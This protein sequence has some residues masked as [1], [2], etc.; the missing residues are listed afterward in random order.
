MSDTI[1]KVTRQP[2]RNRVGTLASMPEAAVSFPLVGAVIALAAGAVVRPFPQLSG[3]AYALWGIGLVVTGV[4]V[5]WRTLGGVVRG[6]LAADV[7]AAIA[8]V[9]AFA[10]GNPAVGLIV[11]IM[12]TGGEAL[13]RYARKRAADTTR[14]LENAAPRLA[15]RYVGHDLVDIPAEAIRVGD[16]LFVR[17]GELIPCDGIVVSGRSHVDVSA[18]TGEPLPVTASAGTQLSSGSLNG[19]GALTLR[20]LALAGESEYARIVELVRTAQQHKAPIQRTAD[21]YAVWF[22]PFTI[23]LAAIAYGISGDW[24][25][26]LAVLVVATPCPLILATPV[27]IIGGVNRAARR[28]IVFRNGTALEQLGQVGMVVLDKTGTITIGRP[29]VTK[30]VTWPGFGR[31]ELLQLAASVEESSSHVLAR[32]L[33]AAAHAEGLD[34]PVATAS[35]EF[36]GQGVSGEVGARTVTVGARSFLEETYPG[37]SNTLGALDGDR[38]GVRAYV[39]VDGSAAGFVDYADA[40]RP[41]LATMRRELEELGLRR[42]ML[43]SGDE[44]SKTRAVAAAAGI[45]EAHGD[46]RP[47]EKAT[48]VSRLVNSG[49]KVVMIGDGTNDAPA[50]STATVGIALAARARGIA[51][52]AADVVVLADDLT[53]VPEAIRLSRRTMRIARQGIVVG[54]GLSVIGMV[55]AAA[56]VLHPIGGAVFQEILD[57]FVITNALRAAR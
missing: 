8:I 5:V 14:E 55:F 12:Q 35:R 48:I 11:V 10:V 27:A 15:H 41:D 4:P 43:L 22:T 25:R 32:S 9:A 45:A 36:A 51:A 28:R 23:A 39:A 13:D 42:L 31:Q 19:E 57:L 24:T 26:V 50:L 49:E 17:A 54:L 20:A 44:A 38:G 2:V 53:R 47:A 30:V 29:L 21:R 52:T 18:L 37:I 16:I 1:E 46:L 3:S 34:V 40:L 6:R 56:G 7:V 33:V